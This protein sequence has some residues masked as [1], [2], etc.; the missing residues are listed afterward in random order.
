MEPYEAISLLEA[1]LRDLVRAELGIVWDSSLSHEDKERL[2]TKQGEESKKRSGSVV[3][4]DLLNYTEFT[5]LQNH[6]QQ[7]PHGVCSYSRSEEVLRGHLSS[8]ERPQKP[9]HAQPA[10]P[11]LR[12]AAAPRALWARSGIRSHCIEQR[13]AL[14]CSITRWST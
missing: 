7:E 6:H 11:F 10:V 9:D 12:A 14:I 13:R 2:R 8:I 5:Q 1:L 4:S 3:S